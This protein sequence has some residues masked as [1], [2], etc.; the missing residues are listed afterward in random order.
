MMESLPQSLIETYIISI[1]SVIFF[2][3]CLHMLIKRI[4]NPLPLIN[5]TDY[6]KT[7]L[8]VKRQY[9]IFAWGLMSASFLMALTFSFYQVFFEI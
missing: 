1:L 5:A 3:F 2:T 8:R 6:S 4:V 9:S 7:A